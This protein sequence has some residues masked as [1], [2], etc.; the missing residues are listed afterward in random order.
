MKI[1]LQETRMLYQSYIAE[2]MQMNRE[3]CPSPEILSECLRNQTSKRNKK[4]V[5]EHISHCRFCLEEFKL[6]LEIQREEM[7]L[8][9]KID[10]LLN[11]DFEKSRTEGK[12]YLF[13]FLQKSWNW[14]LFATGTV[15]VVAVG[16]VLFIFNSEGL[17]QKFRGTNIDHIKLI[18][19]VHKKTIKAPIKFHWRNLENAEYYSLEL[20]DNTLL[21]IWKS[22]KILENRIFL[23]R[24]ILE[25]L[26][27]GKNYYWFITAFFP[28]DR[29]VESSLEQFQIKK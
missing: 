26:S 25:S 7:K 19:P 22:Q 27:S 24:H 1:N 23:P 20:F 9:Q 3:N 11:G 29:K 17:E 16:L 21:P 13:P 4:R 2:S 8:F 6:I 10:N 12:R 5:I 28:G 18:Q 14:I 15:L